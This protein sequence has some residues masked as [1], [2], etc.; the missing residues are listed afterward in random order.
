M[1]DEELTP[2]TTEETE[3]TTE[4]NGVPEVFQT[5]NL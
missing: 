1:S 4:T 3:N 5:V 2:E